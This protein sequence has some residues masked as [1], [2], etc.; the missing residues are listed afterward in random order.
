[1]PNLTE[2]TVTPDG[3]R[4]EG[5]TQEHRRVRLSCDEARGKSWLPRQS[6][7]YE[8]GFKPHFVGLG[9]AA[10]EIGDK[11]C[12]AASRRKPKAISLRQWEGI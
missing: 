2:T 11:A 7:C 5:S 3:H 10:R 8:H 4:I 6:N 9:G 12:Q 1:M